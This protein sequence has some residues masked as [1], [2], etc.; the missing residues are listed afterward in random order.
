MHSTPCRARVRLVVL[1]GG[2]VGRARRVLRVGGHVL[3]AADPER[4]DARAG[5]HHPRRASGC[6]PT[7]A[8][9]RRSPSGARRA[10]RAARRPTAPTLEPL[11]TVAAGHAGRAGRRPPA[12]PR[13]AGRGRHGAGPARAGRR[14]LRRLRRAR[15]RAVHGQGHGQGRARRRHPAGPLDRRPA[16]STSTTRSLA[17]WSTSSGCPVFVKPANLGSSVGVTKAHDPDRAAR[18]RRRPRSPT[19]SGCVVEEAVDR[20]RDRGRRCSATPTPRASV[21]GE[22]VPEPRVL[23]LRRQVPRRRGRAA[24]P[25]RRCPT[26]SPRR[27]ARSPSTRSPRCAA[28]AWP[29]STSST[30]SRRPRPA[31]QRDQHDPGVHPV[32]DVPELWAATGLPLRRARSTSWSAWPSSATTTA[33]GTAPQPLTADSTP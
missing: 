7:S 26:T 8:V 27:S 28:T 22:I 13:P 19:T 20:P 5:R 32:L 25:R 4:Y 21:P 1:F 9:A 6:S 31:A 33:T 15:L 29:G 24:H 18:R 3:R 12:A 17:G 23:R 14:A 30:R 11:P 16:T 10:A 2:R